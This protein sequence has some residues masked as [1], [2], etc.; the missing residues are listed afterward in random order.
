[1]LEFTRGVVLSREQS[2]HRDGRRKQGRVRAIGAL[3]S[4]A[5]LLACG[6]VG[7]LTWNASD[8]V[9]HPPRVSYAGLIRRYRTLASQAVTFHGAGGALISGR[10]FPG[11]TRAT[12]ILSHG[13][14]ATQEQMLPWASFLHQAGFSVLTYDMR[15]V[16]TAAA[17][18][19]LVRWNNA[20]WSRRWTT[21]CRGPTLTRTG[22]RPSVSPWAVR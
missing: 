2:K 13:Y 3:G 19:P 17:P 15:G 7:I 16:G 20:T 11:R 22:S 4:A 18:S 9:L 1:M 21:W 10:F 14:G 12:I 6:L 5:L 8:R